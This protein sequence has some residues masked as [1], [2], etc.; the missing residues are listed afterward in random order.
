M[1]YKILFFNFTHIS[2]T[3]DEILFNFSEKYIICTNVRIREF[4]RSKKNITHTLY[5]FLYFVYEEARIIKNN[6][7][8]THSR[9]YF[10]VRKSRDLLFEC[11]FRLL[12][13]PFLINRF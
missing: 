3:Y 1:C 2:H 10:L 6:I 5:Y 9:T 11:K 4:E 8:S 12:L 7:F 13:P